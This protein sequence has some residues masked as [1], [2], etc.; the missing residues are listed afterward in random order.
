MRLGNASI[1]T[2]H[3]QVSLTVDSDK[4]IKKNVKTSKLGLEF[5]DALR[6]VDYK[7]KNPHSW[8]DELKEQRFKKE[9]PDKKPED[10]PVTYNGFIAQEVKKVMDA[11]GIT[12][13]DGWRQ[14]D[15]SMQSLTATA[16]IGPLVKAVQE[17]AARVVKLEGKA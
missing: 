12:N 5:L 8:P 7:K 10:D 3:C 6:P 1:A 15:N 9:N 14:A 4:R 13:W 11:Q 2:L 17:L 16:L